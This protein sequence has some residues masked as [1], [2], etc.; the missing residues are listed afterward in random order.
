MINIIS[1]HT[2]MR[3]CPNLISHDC[4]QAFPD[5][6]FRTQC[7]FFTYSH[8]TVSPDYLFRV[9]QNRQG[10]RRFRFSILCHL[11]HLLAGTGRRWKMQRSTHQS[12][13]VLGS[14]V[15]DSSCLFWM[16]RGVPLFWCSICNFMNAFGHS[17]HTQLDFCILSLC[18]PA[19]RQPNRFPLSWWSECCHSE[20]SAPTISSVKYKN[21]ILSSNNIG[22]LHRSIKTRG[23]DTWT[24]LRSERSTS[25]MIHRT[26]A[27][28]SHPGLVNIVCNARLNQRGQGSFL[29]VIVIKV[30]ITVLRKHS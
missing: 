6:L 18:L 5:S 28:P 11:F 1:L 22:D 8:L 7:R 10:P 20:F 27:S 24:E 17:H 25:S 13:H 19:C 9:D 29:E 15:V 21:F 3:Y 2:N 26:W 12:G 16:F 4:P 23:P 30:M 14:A